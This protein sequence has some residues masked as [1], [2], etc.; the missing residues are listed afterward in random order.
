MD[1]PVITLSY[2]ETLSTSDLIKLA[3][4]YGIDIPEDLNRRFIIGELLEAAEDANDMEEDDLVPSEKAV[5]LQKELPKTYNESQLSVVIRNPAW[6]YVYWDIR[7]SDLEQ[8]TPENGFLNLSLKVSFYE[9]KYAEKP[10]DTYDIN[11]ASNI[12]EQYVL[13]PAE[14]YLLKLELTA[15]FSSKPVLT[16]A[17][18]DKI[19]IPKGASEISSKGLMKDISPILELSGFQKLLQSQYLQHRESFI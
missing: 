9:D 1:N 5:R 6:C 19:E 2:L 11:L 15:D 4:D 18:S 3:D 13:L 7:A 8:L 14:E 12:R 17:Q 10:R 16:I